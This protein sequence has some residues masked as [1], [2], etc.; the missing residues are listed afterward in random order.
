MNSYYTDFCF[1]KM[2][3][4]EIVKEEKV[5]YLDTDTNVVKEISNIWDYD[6]SDVY[7]TG[8]KDW[9]IQERGNIEELGIKEEWVVDF[10]YS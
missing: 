9:K 4:Q 5:L 1:G 8:V 7:I 2:V 10:R 6:I 3:L